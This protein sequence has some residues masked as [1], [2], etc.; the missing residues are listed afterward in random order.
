MAQ[1]HM[2]SGDVSRDTSGDN[3]ASQY[4]SFPWSDSQFDKQSGS[5]NKQNTK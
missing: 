1:Q 3:V 2:V 5:D 4:W